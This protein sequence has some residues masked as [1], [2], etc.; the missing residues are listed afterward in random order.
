[1]RDHTHFAPGLQPMGQRPEGPEPALTQTEAR[2]PDR[3]ESVI[4]ELAEL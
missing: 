1:M 2:G 3:S 4:A